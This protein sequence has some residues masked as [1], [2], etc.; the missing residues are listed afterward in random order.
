MRKILFILL[1]LALLG[2]A[3]PAFA[4]EEFKDVAPNH[5]ALF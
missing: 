2:L 5:W 4:C 1:F 3:M